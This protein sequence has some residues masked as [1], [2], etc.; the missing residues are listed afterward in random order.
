MPV[1]ARTLLLITLPC[2]PLSAPSATVQRCEDTNGH[3]TF[4]SQGCA[5]TD[6]MQSYEA[7][8]APPGSGVQLLP[9]ANRSSPRSQGAAKKELV[10][11]GQHD[12]GC[13]NRISSEQRR[14]AIINQR[15]L[16]GM[17]LR[18]VESALGKPNKIANRNGE[19]RYYYAE[20]KG[21][22]SQVVFDENGCVKGKG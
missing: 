20:K 17:S 11:V 2:F 9:E 14:R 1:T 19:T 21:R 18:D 12:D 15:T 16:A 5:H 8:N 10:V 22:S 13:G 6:R 4:T 7:Y 3:I